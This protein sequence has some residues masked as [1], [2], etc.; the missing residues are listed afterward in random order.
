MFILFPLLLGI[1]QGLAEFLPVSSSGHLALFQ[2]FFGNG[3]AKYDSITAFNVLLHLGTLVAVFIVYRKDLAAMLPALLS[4]PKKLWKHKTGIRL[5]HLNYDERMVISV[6][7]ATLPLVF[8]KLFD[9]VLEKLTSFSLLDAMEQYITNQ[10]ISVGLILIFNGLLLFFS[11]RLVRKER[12][13]EDFKPLNALLVGIFQMFAILPGLSRSGSTITGGRLNGLDRPSAVRFSF[14]LSIPAILG[15]CV[16]ELPELFSDSSL[17]VGDW[18]IFLAATAVAC[19]V[20]LASMKLLDYIAKKSSFKPFSYYCFAVGT[21][22]V[23]GGVL[24]LVL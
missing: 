14:L 12:P 21:L 5:S 23:I 18:L 24:L 7:V 15:S 3:L 4:I 8:L 10:P 22:A 9:I 13:I 17:R 20:G 11:D 6:V 2:S 16:T 1:V 19:L